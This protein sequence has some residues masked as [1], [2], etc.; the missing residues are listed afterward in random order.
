M[1]SVG[2]VTEKI[3]ASRM[4]RAPVTLVSALHK[5]LNDD[6]RGCDDTLWHPTFIKMLNDG[7]LSLSAQRHV[8]CTVGSNRAGFLYVCRGFAGGK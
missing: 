3:R 5:V 1:F 7:A 6:A 8:A 2:N 4:G